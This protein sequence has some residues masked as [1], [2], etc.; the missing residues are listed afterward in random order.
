MTSRRRFPAPQPLSDADDRAAF[1]CGRD[2]LNMGVI[3]HPLDDDLRH[4][5]A[6]WG[7]ED[8]PHDPMRAMIVRMKDLRQNGFGGREGT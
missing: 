6:R 7:F 4:F 2:S 8:L 5:Y 3:T 1:D